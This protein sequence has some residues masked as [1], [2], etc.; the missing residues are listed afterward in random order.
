MGIPSASS[1]CA[2]T[3]PAYKTPKRNKL[4]STTISFFGIGILPFSR[5]LRLVSGFDAQKR[6][7]VA[8]Q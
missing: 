1:D 6:H 2:R 5:V 4:L 8:L 3:N 7:F